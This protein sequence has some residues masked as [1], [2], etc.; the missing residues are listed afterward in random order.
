MTNNI[1]NKNDNKNEIISH[2]VES[3]IERLKNNGVQAGRTEADNIMKQ[4]QEQADKMINDARDEADLL[5]SNANKKIQQEKQAAMDALE[6]AARN[7]RLELRQRMISRFK[8]EVKRLVHKELDNESIIRQIILLLAVD[9]AEQLQ[10][11]KDSQIE[12]Q[13]PEKALDFDKIR[14]N[15]KLLENDPLKK[16]VQGATSEMLRAG[17]N[18]KVN[19]DKREVGIKVRI[20]GEDIEL[21]LTEEAITEILLKHLQPRFR[22]LLEGLLQ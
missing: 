18:L 11:F 7:M 6:L 9:T 12:I 16:L 13:L 4:A 17:M 3:L 21:D 1:Y 5:I 2:N 8:E 19:T 15:P 22:A 20:V 10:K 14:N